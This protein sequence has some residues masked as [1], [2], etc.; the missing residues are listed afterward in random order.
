[1]ENDIYNDKR[2]PGENMIA[3]RK[4]REANKLARRKNSKGKVYWPSSIAGTFTEEKAA[5]LA[6]DILSKEG[7]ITKPEDEEY[8]K[9]VV[10][11][12]KKEEKDEILNRSESELLD[13]QKHISNRTVEKPRRNRKKNAKKSRRS[14]STNS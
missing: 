10:E 6:E 9:L 12:N 8:E 14:V 5:K 11:R 3:Y 7:T 2:L 1:M 13:G 4:R